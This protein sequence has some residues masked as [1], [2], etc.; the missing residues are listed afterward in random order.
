MALPLAFLQVLAQRLDGVPHL[1]EQVDKLLVI[2]ECMFP[3]GRRIRL[4]EWSAPFSM[5][6]SARSRVGRMYSC[7]FTALIESQT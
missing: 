5:T 2:H 3:R 4:M 6:T 1:F 7:R